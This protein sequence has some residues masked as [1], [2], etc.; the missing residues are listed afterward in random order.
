MTEQEEQKLKRATADMNSS[1][2]ALNDKEKERLGITIRYLPRLLESEILFNRGSAAAGFG[3]AQES[4]ANAAVLNQEK[5][6]R[7]IVANIKEANSSQELDTVL[8]ELHAKQAISLEQY[9]KAQVQL[10]RLDKILR[11]Y[12][13]SEDLQKVDAILQNF[14]NIIGLNTS[15]SMSA[16]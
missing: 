15:V 4:R 3:K 9:N 14:F 7:T 6:I 16:K 2:Q 1:I 8:D 13:N 5:R 10:H 11:G 12:K